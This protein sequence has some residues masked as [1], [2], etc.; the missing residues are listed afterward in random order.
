MKE[1]EVETEKLNQVEEEEHAEVV[2]IDFSQFWGELKGRS[3][4]LI[5]HFNRK[6]GTNIS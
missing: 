1:E 6:L 2:W 5:N 3:L 4:K